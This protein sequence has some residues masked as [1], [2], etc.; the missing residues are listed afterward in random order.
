MFERAEAATE[1]LAYADLPDNP[2][3]QV[4]SIAQVRRMCRQVAFALLKLGDKGAHMLPGGWLPSEYAIQ[5]KSID[6]FFASAPPLDPADR[7]WPGAPIV[8]VTA[9]RDGRSATITAV[10]AGR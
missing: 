1:E 10:G 9:D 2:Y 7:A 5:L 3:L 8:T 4:R 6:D